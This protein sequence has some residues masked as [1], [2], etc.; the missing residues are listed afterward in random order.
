MTDK[1]NPDSPVET[2]VVAYEVEADAFQA[3]LA[4]LAELPYNK[5]GNIL[6]ELRRAL[7]IHASEETE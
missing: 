5:V 4:A 7:P 3:G 1:A 6:N 2:P